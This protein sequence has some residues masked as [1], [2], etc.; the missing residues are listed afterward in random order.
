MPFMETVQGL[1][2]EKHFCA[3]AT[4]TWEGDHCTSAKIR[5]GIKV[6]SSLQHK[7]SKSSHFF[8]LAHMPYCTCQGLDSEDQQNAPEYTGTEKSEQAESELGL[9]RPPLL[10]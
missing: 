4:Q 3:K 8:S 10:V 2:R 7:F 5:L 9:F 1:I 6:D